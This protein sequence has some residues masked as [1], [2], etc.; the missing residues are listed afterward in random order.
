M[1]SNYKLGWTGYTSLRQ[2]LKTKVDLPA[3]CRLMQHKNSIMPEIVYL[4][5]SLSGV[6]LRVKESIQLH[7]QRLI[8]QLGLEPGKY[9]MKVKEGLDGSG[10][11]SG[12]DQKGNVETHNMIMWMW[13]ALEVYKDDQIL[14]ADPSL[15]STSSSTSRRV[16]VWKESCPSSP[17][18][19][20]PILLVLGKEDKDLLKKIVPL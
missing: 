17:D 14:N 4:T 1:L 3:H 6:S 7:F 11:H 13:V 10:R 15:P 5:D 8:K 18:A 9:T 16:V 2:E 20:Q 12:Y 19:A